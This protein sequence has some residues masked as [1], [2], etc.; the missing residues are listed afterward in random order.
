MIRTIALI[1]CFLGLVAAPLH[2]ADDMETMLKKVTVKVSF[3][4]SG[5]NMAVTVSLTNTNKKPCTD[6]VVRV[7]FFD[8]DGNEVLTDA[9]AYFATIKPKATKR[10]ET[11]LW[12]DVPPEAVTAT[13]KLDA[14]VFD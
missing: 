9:K 5:K 4:R 14:A 7:T 6:P 2:A 3:S 11:R 13:G 12:R 1:L 8:K 10:M